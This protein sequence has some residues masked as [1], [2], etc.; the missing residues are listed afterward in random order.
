MNQW[1]EVCVAIAVQQY[2]D[3]HS[4]NIIIQQWEAYNK[5][6]IY[7]HCRK[8]YNLFVQALETGRKTSFSRLFRIE[9]KL[10]LYWMTMYVYCVYPAI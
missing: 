3:H 7:I 5:Y 4:V 10:I 2:I 6:T 1:V 9:C 8:I